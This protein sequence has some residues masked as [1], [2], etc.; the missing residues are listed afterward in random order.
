[1]IRGSIKDKPDEWVKRFTDG[2]LYRFKKIGE[3]NGKI[4][5]VLKRVK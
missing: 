2:K 1:M 3:K 4:R 5:C